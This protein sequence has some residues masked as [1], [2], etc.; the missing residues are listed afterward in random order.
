[1]KDIFET[2]RVFVMTL[3]VSI[4]IGSA[5]LV[6]AGATDATTTKPDKATR[7]K[8][9]ENYGKLPLS[10]VQNGGQMDNKVKF[11]ERS[12]GHS[13]YFTTDGIYL[14]LISD[15]KIN[16]EA[17][18]TKDNKQIIPKSKTTK[19]KNQVQ[20]TAGGQNLKSETIKLTPIGANKNPKIIAEG[21]QR[22]KVNYFIGND[23]KE[24]KTN[25]PTYQAVVYENIYKGIDMKFYG[26]NH[27]M[28]YDIMVKP[29]IDL[30]IVRLA[31][32]GIQALS[33]TKEGALEI[34]LKEG[35]VIQN[36]PYCYQDIDGKRVEVKGGFKLLKNAKLAS[37][38]SEEYVYGFKVGS[39]NRKYPLIVDP[40]LV[41]STF[42]GGSHP[43]GGA[44]IAVDAF[45]NAYV[46]GSTM[47][48]DF[49]TTFS[50]YE[51]T[52]SG[53]YDAFV[54]KLDPTGS[55]II[56]ST[57]LGGTEYRNGDKATCIE[58]DTSGN[59][60]VGGVTFSSD[61]PTTEG[62]Y[63][64]V[65]DGRWD[66]GEDAFITKL[67]PTG[68]SLMYSTYLGTYHI[69][70]LYDIAVDALGHAYV[71]GL[72]YGETFPTTDG[73]IRKC[74]PFGQCAD[75]FVTKLDPTGTSLVYSTLFGGG[76]YD[77][78]IGIAIDAS[79]YAY[80]TG[81][82]WPFSDIP[83]TEGA[84]DTDFNGGDYD[85]FVAKLDSTSPSVL[86]YTLLGGSHSEK[87]TGIALDTSGNVYVA[88]VTLSGDFPT[89]PDAFDK[90]Y[91]IDGSTSNGDVFVAKLD[92]TFSSLV[93]STF[94]GGED[95]DWEA[96][97][98]VDT[99]GN[100]YV[101][102][103]TSSVY[104]PSTPDAFDP[105]KN[106]SGEDVF[107]SKLDPTGTSLLY[108]TFL[109][110]HN[111][112]NDHL[113]G[114]HGGGIAIDASRN[115]YVT[116]YTKQSDFPTTEGA[117]DETYNG[118][119][120]FL[121][122]GDA[123]VAKLELLQDVDEDG[124][125]STDDC[126][127][128]DPDVYPG[129]P[130]L[131]D[132]KDNDCDGEIDEDAI[133][134]YFD[135]DGDGFGNPAISMQA[136]E[137]P[138]GYVEDNTDCDDNDANEHP[139]QTWYKDADGDGYSDGTTD[140]TS[141]ERPTGYKVESELTAISG[142][143]DDDCAVCYPG[144]G[145]DTTTSYTGAFVVP[146]GNVTVSVTIVDADSN[147]VTAGSVLFVLVDGYGN[148]FTETDNTIT[149]GNA[150]ATIF[151]PVGVYTVTISFDGDDCLL[152]DSQTEVTL[153]VYDPS[154]GF[155][156]G[157]G[158]INSPEGAY[159]DDVI[160]TGKANFGFVSRYKKGATIPTGQTEFVF[161]AADLNFHSSEYQWLVVTGANYAKFK[162]SG[163]INGAG[164][165]KFMIWAGDTAPDTFRIRIWE[166][167]GGVETDKY[168]NGTD[169]PIGGGNIVVH[170]K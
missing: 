154:A 160:A 29:G 5:G 140:T 64:S 66:W 34:G 134:Y 79:G 13:T 40:G 3:A 68:S 50:A 15:K 52:N 146:T 104:F 127:D 151:V 86:Y 121:D 94:L 88:G 108:S 107:V 133:T 73:T 120:G 89:T 22:G 159:K 43:D 67:D 141:C 157:G 63:D 100:A 9:N 24:W 163:T 101:A 150:E 124:F 138:Q 54:T 77:A 115:V 20:Q 164:D 91:G 116:G 90:I 48:L 8:L 126:D 80:V 136:C 82:V 78:G 19:S 152:A 47:S 81:E 46:A 93:Y 165:Y 148:T 16:A 118:H 112:E 41:Y 58:I 106:G 11:Y 155:V 131:C 59:A 23:P 42:L 84:Y 167:F 129:A 71:T 85:A 2:K 38:N 158:W 145:K 128:T 117:F 33:I 166:E 75:A 132:G 130:E 32:E 105:S 162:G 35:K 137:A 31:Y 142:D 139:G 21:M 83:V 113:Q 110:G 74:V 28:E 6:N 56:Y 12:S 76:N 147:P 30:S 10:F 7:A 168:D 143:C 27:Q 109:G 122:P 96:D 114:N 119:V 149:I 44:D 170:R 95:V 99:S 153:A 70:R 61:F 25:I 103:T 135:F 36:R 65:Y 72:T 62:A 53:H 45:G 51:T 92:S 4:I 102:G 17:I 57:Y 97:I 55:T 18:N 1:M 37:R 49:P 87:G 156:T 161:K 169:Q 14:E 26:N 69:D 144:G 39:Y 98:T 125:S 60:Y 111:S 123:F